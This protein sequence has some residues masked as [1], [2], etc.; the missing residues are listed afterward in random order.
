MWFLFSWNAY[1]Y[2]EILLN[3]KSTRDEI[4]SEIS[5][6]YC[7]C[8]GYQSIVDAIEECINEIN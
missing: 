8:T 3:K 4:R 7:R 6:N 5:G 1:D 2:K